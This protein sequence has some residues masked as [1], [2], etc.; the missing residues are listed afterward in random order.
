MG[1]SPMS[2]SSYETPLVG[3]I[4]FTP[5]APSKAEQDV[6]RQRTRVLERGHS[7]PVSP[8]P[9]PKRFTVL[10][11]VQAERHLVA[12]V[13]YP[14]CTSYE[15]RKVLVFADTRA[16]DLCAATELDP[17]FTDVAPAGALVPVARFEPTE[18]GWRLAMLT[19]WAL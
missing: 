17:H 6:Q 9:N 19:A 10:R 2:K 14:D 8:N 4:T 11:V 18:R 7:A 5:Q 16:G 15:G 13:H 3:R 1:L 12:L